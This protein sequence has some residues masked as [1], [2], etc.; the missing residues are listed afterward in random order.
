MLRGPGGS[1]CPGVYAQGLWGHTAYSS[2]NLPTTNLCLKDQEAYLGMTSV[3][4]ALG[5]RSEIFLV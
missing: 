4:K 1:P 3:R 2:Q 5:L